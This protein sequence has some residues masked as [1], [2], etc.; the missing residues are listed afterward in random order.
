MSAYCRKKKPEEIP[1]QVMPGLKCGF[2]V[3]I[4]DPNNQVH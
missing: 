2:L 1:N 4:V 3:G